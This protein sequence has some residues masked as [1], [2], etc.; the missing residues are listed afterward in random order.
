[1][2][3]R[4]SVDHLGELVD[5]RSSMTVEAGGV[6]QGFLAVNVTVR[7]A[8]TGENSIEMDQRRVLHGCDMIIGGQGKLHGLPLL[9]NEH[10]I[11]KEG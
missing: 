5:E 3:L 2:D 4:K 7:F 8:Y 10:L 6:L 1:M 9:A 11:Y